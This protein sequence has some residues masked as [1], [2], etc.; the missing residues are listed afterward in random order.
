MNAGILRYSRRGRLTAVAAFQVVHVR[1]PLAAGDRWLAGILP[2]APPCDTLPR[3]RA[4]TGRAAGGTRWRSVAPHSSLMAWSAML[5]GAHDLGTL[6]APAHL[7]PSLG[8]SRAQCVS[9][10]SETIVRRA[11]CQNGVRPELWE[12]QVGNCPRRRS[13]ILSACTILCMVEKDE[14]RQSGA[15]V[16]SVNL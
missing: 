3:E 1:H 10:N 2:P 14:P 11:G 15:P 16:H 13:C 9:L 12:P 4:A 8:T 7:S 6:R 5:A